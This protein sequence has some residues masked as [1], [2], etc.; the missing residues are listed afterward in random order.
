MK[1]FGLIL[2]IIIGG[3][4]IYGTLDMPP[5]GDTYS[6]ASTHVSSRYI[7]KALEETHAPNIVTSLLA[8]YRGFDTLGETI[9]IF[10]AGIACIILLRN[11]TR[12]KND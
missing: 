12:K 4:L 7:E 11:A 2:V 9:V 3:F 6:P 5:W 10:T 1:I 8:D